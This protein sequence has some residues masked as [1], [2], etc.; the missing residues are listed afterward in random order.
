MSNANGK[1]RQ[2]TVSLCALRGFVFFSW[3]DETSS[4]KNSCCDRLARSVLT[5]RLPANRP[6]HR[7]RQNFRQP[8]KAQSPNRKNGK[9]TCRRGKAGNGD[10]PLQRWAPKGSRRAR[11]TLRRE[12]PTFFAEGLT[13]RGCARNNINRQ[14]DKDE[15][16]RSREAKTEEYLES[17]IEETTFRVSSDGASIARPTPSRY[18]R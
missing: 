10:L 18:G 17:F 12:I 3:V 16:K 9:A 2:P 1:V 11:K 13:A 15:R 4:R 7:F 6:L 14:G 5:T 8:G